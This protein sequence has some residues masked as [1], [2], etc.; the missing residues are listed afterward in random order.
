MGHV[1][2]V[3]APVGIA[4]SRGVIARARLAKVSAVPTQFI[5]KQYTEGLGRA[6]TVEE[7][8]HWVS[9]FSHK[10]RSCGAPSMTVL[11]RAVFLSSEFDRLRYRR[12]EA[13]S[14]LSRAVL[15]HDLDAATYGGIAPTA[16]AGRKL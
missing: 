14:A 11:V 10:G 16:V 13:L 8:E 12:V 2:S 7:W 1:E 3:E 5:A 15:N 6:P 9:F 4:G